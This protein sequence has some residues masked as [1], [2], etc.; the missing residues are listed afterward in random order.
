MKAKNKTRVILDKDTNLKFPHV[1]IID[2]SAGTGKTHTLTQRFVQYILSKRVHHNNL[3]NILA[4]TFTNNAAREMKQ[5]ILDWLKKLALGIDCEERRQTLEL[6]DL[7]PEQITNQARIALENILEHWSDFHIQT[8]D[9]FMSRILRA[10]AHEIGMPLEIDITQSYDVLTD[11][12]LSIVLNSIND[13]DS[14]E[15]LGRFLEL[16]NQEVDSFPWNPVTKI[17]DSFKEFLKEEGKALEKILFEDNTALIQEKFTD[18]YEIYKKVL[19]NGLENKI[20]KDIHNAMQTRDIKK[21]LSAFD[22]EALWFKK[23]GLSQ[24]MINSYKNLFPIVEELALLYSKSHYFHYGIF[25]EKFKKVLNTEKRKEEIIHFDDINKILSEYLKRDNVPEVYYRLGDTLY[26]FLL[27]EFQDTDRV[28][29]ENIQPLLYEAYAKGGTFFAV[30]DMKQAIYLFRKADY[31]IMRKIVQEIKNKD[32]YSTSSYLPPNV[33]DN[34]R[35][36][37]LKENFRSGNVILSYVDSIFKDRLKQIKDSIQLREDRTG[38]TDYTQEAKKEY[39]GYVKTIIL[40]KNDEELEKKVLLEILADVRKRYSPRDIAILARKNKHIEKIVEWL[41]ENSID[42]A[43]F[44]SLNI[45]KRKIIMEIVNLLQFLDT[46]I[47]N[48]SFA[49]FITGDIF[50]RAVESQGRKIKREEIFKFIMGVPK[51]KNTL[52]NLYVDFRESLEYSSLWKIFFE[53][54]FTKVGFYPLYD[55]VCQCFRTFKIFENFKEENGFLIRFLEAISTIET[56]GMNNIKDFLKLVAEDEEDSILNVMLPDYID[57]VKVMTFHKAKGLGFP[58]VINM[59]YDEKDRHYAMFF[60]K[61]KG[62]LKLYYVTKSFSGKFPELNRIY[63][64]KTQDELIQS[65][66]LIYVANTRA[67]NELYNIVIRRDD[68][69][70]NPCID[71]FEEFENGEKLAPSEE[72]IIKPEPTEIKIPEK[73]EIEF[74]EEDS[75]G[76]SIKRILETKRG[77]FFHEIL[78]HLIFI[79]DNIDKELDEIIK[80]IASRYKEIYDI[81]QVKKTILDFLDIDIVKEWFEEKPDR[82]VQQEIEYVNENGILYRPDRVIIDKDRITVIDFKTGSE[83]L[84]YYST[85]LKGYIKILRNLNQQ[86]EVEGYIAFIETK[87]IIKIR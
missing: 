75:K 72:K 7:N 54:L 2:A 19:N 78:A 74:I 8:I 35:V 66:N 36:I 24:E 33:I 76:W 32:H 3:S 44:S 51:Q 80:S 85:Q 77:E 63:S 10:S 13:R 26:H 82:Q 52:E 30:G 21:L 57:A 86:K 84:D 39:Q 79:K 37:P 69:H 81:E 46:P 71:L 47:D 60:E 61:D 43:S 56:R 87:K 50:L 64:E 45:R 62:N 34:A 65:L 9:S 55:L 20:K 23:T 16:L 83:E 31:R 28:Q 12:A 67:M 49:T 29:W 11:S 48:L 70:H 40:E 5:R 22:P 17:I 42:T 4:I 18:I 68:Q 27:D 15:E 14:F 73:C 59:F 41:T 25:Y 58:V 53:D 1:L 6:V 38:L